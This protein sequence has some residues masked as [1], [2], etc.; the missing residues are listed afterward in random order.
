MQLLDNLFTQ[1]E[2]IHLQAL[3]ELEQLRVL[4]LP[5]SL[6]EF[7]LGVLA[8]HLTAGASAAG[9]RPWPSASLHRVLLACA[10]ATT[11]DVLLEDD[12]EAVLSRPR[13][14]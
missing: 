14:N 12:D 1:L 9:H 7:L 3:T 4:G 6:G 8:E 10:L 2:S 11:G 5:F 13:S